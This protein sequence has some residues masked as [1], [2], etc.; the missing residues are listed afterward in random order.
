MHHHNRACPDQYIVQRVRDGLKDI[1]PIHILNMHTYRNRDPHLDSYY[2]QL[3]DDTPELPYKKERL[4][5]S[6]IHIGQLKLLHSE[7][8]VLL[9]ELYKLWQEGKLSVDGKECG[10]CDKKIVVI[11][12]G[13]ASGAHLI[14]L[15][16]LF[17]LLEFELIDP[18]P[19]DKD[20]VY[21]KQISTHNEYFT[22]DL[23]KMYAKKYKDY[24]IVLVSDIRTADFSTQT[25]AEVEVAV[26][27]DMDMQNDW[28]RIIN[29]IL[30]IYKFRAPYVYDAT[31]KQTI[32]YLHGY[33][34]LQV[35]PPSSST[36][37]RLIAYKNA[38]DST[39]DSRKI[40]SQCFYHNAISRGNIYIH[41]Y[42]GICGLDSC[43]DCAALVECAALHIKML[44]EG[45]PHVIEE[46]GGS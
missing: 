18:N 44:R 34:N 33:L 5:K 38:P 29:P 15:A 3:T 22:D 21:Y 32:T 39:Y 27:R 11:Y 19:F 13:G 31:S 46:G 20:L 30:C 23:A 9:E 37:L 26:Q 25:D 2:S 1:K 12:P 24:L 14:Y 42:E 17:P 4:Y 40:E 28:F 10:Q 43:Y 8:K 36:E 16:K 7:W 35:V 6:S 45:F 41:G